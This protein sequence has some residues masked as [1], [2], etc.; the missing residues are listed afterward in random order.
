MENSA[1]GRFDSNASD[2]TVWNIF[3]RSFTRKAIVFFA[4]VILLY[5]VIIACIINL[6]IR[7][8]KSKIWI[9]LLS[10][11]LGYILPN[12]TLEIHPK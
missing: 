1:I 5:I 3:G 9:V 11:C 7:E 6:T 2:V 8:E 4:Q 12:P 10:A